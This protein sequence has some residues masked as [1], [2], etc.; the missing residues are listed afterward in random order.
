MKKINKELLQS[1]KVLYVEDEE[2][3]RE[4]VT[5][6]FKKYMPNFYTAKNGEEGIEKFNSIKPDLVITDIQMPKL[7]GIDMIKELNTTIPI[8]I[9][10]AYS[11]IEFF[12][13]AIELKVLKFVIKPINLKELIFDI[14]DAIIGLKLKDRLYEKEN[15]LNIVDENV[16]L[17][18]TDKD[19]IIIDASSAFCDFVK[20][21]KDELLG[22]THKI[23]KHE[24]TPDSFYENMWKII[25]SGKVYKGDVRNKKKNGDKYWANITITPVFNDDGIIENYTAIRQDITNKKILEQLAIE[26][27][28]TKLYNR[29]Y[30]NIIIEKEI[31]RIKREESS[32]S[33]ACIDID[34]FKSFNDTY[35]HPKGDDALSKVAEVFKKMSA[36]GSDF[37]FRMGGEEFCI[38]F[39]GV[40]KND[41][42]SFIKEVVSEIE[43]LHIEH[44]TSEC[45]RYLTVSAGL[46]VLTSKNLLDSS[47]IYSYADKALYEAKKRGKNQVYLSEYE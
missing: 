47:K 5:Y 35:G 18:I 16:L 6:F 11:D 13:Q 39:S 30:F 3:I 27:E 26:D 25:S 2:M 41:S 12:L 20:Y 42:L 28:L 1:I 24:K 17:S 36:R 10:T 7:N 4:E 29:R 32:L 15:L 23:L 38:I 46:I 9:T 33:L 37:A 44:T 19:G 40:S 31:G 8:I 21:T 14:Q 43:N 45:S 34:Y 22:N